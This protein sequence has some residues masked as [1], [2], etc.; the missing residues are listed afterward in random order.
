MIVNDSS[1]CELLRLTNNTFPA[2]TKMVFHLASYY[3]FYKIR[4]ACTMF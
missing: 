3:R 2:H 1:G 4:E